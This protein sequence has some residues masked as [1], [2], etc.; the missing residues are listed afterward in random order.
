MRLFLGILV[1]TALC[2][3]INAIAAGI[4][5]AEVLYMNHGPMQPTIREL[6]TVFANYG[7]KIAVSWYD[8]DTGEAQQFAARK[9]LHEHIPLNIWIDGSQTIKLAQ[10]TVRFSGFPSGSGP[11]PFQGDWTMQDLR[12]AIDQAISRKR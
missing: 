5:H 7:D 11:K 10:R 4:P 1:L 3:G 12:A 2:L 6:K 9:G 8:I